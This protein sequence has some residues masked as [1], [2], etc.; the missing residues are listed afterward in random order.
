MGNTCHDACQAR[1]SGCQH[2]SSP[3]NF[4]MQRYTDM[5]RDLIGRSLGCH[6]TFAHDN[7][8]DHVLRKRLHKMGLADQCSVH[9]RM[10]R[11][12]HGTQQSIGSIAWSCDAENT[13]PEAH[14]QGIAQLFHAVLPTS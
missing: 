4:G 3:V 6:L 13:M 5:F 11:I 12:I 14:G 1:G 9:Q 2:G 8:R 10:Y 7:A